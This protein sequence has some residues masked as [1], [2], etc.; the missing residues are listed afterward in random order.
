MIRTAN[1]AQL[2]TLGTLTNSQSFISGDSNWKFY[3]LS[4][5]VGTLK[6]NIQMQTFRIWD[7]FFLILIV[8]KNIFYF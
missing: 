8:L 7:F 2:L 6:P 1:L 4:Y 5:P 3:K